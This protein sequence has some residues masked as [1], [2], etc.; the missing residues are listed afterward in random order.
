MRFRPIASLSLIVMTLW[1][2]ACASE[3]EVRISVLHHFDKGN[4]AFAEAD[5]PG[6]IQHFRT[7]LAL[8]PRSADIWYNLGLAYYRMAD[9]EQSVD[10]FEQARELAP[11]R[12]EFHYNLAL[13]YHERYDLPAAHRSYQLYLALAGPSVKDQVGAQNAAQAPET[14]PSGGAA[15]RAGTAA[16]GTAARPAPDVPRLSGNLARVPGAQ[17]AQEALGAQAASRPPAQKRAPLRRDGSRSGANDNP[18]EGHPEW[19]KEDLP[20]Q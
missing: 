5:Y 16:A 2:G 6:A 8:D 7:A 17:E 10:A 4:E 11:T 19:W 20:Q 13:A 1:L 12:P 3:Q 14:A 18:F 9:F 15:T